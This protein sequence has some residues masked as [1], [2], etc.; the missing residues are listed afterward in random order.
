MEIGKKMNVKEK[1]DEAIHDYTSY[2][3]DLANAELNLDEM[4]IKH[5]VA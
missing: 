4:E 2:E 5:R 3:I 1:I